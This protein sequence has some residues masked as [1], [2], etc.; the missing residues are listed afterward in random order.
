MMDKFKLHGDLFVF[1]LKA[2]CKSEHIRI[3]PWFFELQSHHV[4]R[5]LLRIKAMNYD[6]IA[7]K[8]NEVLCHLKAFSFQKIN[9]QLEKTQHPSTIKRD[10]IV[11]FGEVL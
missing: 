2:V 5:F 9:S 10:C 6:C 8:F 7:S 11:N 1:S 3:S 4:C